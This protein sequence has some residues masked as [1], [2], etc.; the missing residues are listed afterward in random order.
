MRTAKEG[1][2]QQSK[3]VGEGGGGICQ[4]DGDSSR[5]SSSNAHV[6]TPGDKE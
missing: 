6:A 5:Q 3:D 2:R 4:S 1:S